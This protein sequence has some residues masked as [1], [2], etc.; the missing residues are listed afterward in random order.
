MTDSRGWY[1]AATLPPGRYALKVEIEGFVTHQ[2]G[3]LTLTIGQ[4]ATVNATLQI[5][6]LQETVSVTAEAP[7]GVQKILMQNGIQTEPLKPIALITTSSS[8]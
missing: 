4:E 6:T 2:R 7:P 5:A 8:F 1:R 3:G